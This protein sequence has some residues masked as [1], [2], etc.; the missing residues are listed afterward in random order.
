MISK[1]T[2]KY[3]KI[4]STVAL[5]VIV[6]MAVPLV[7]R[8]VDG[9]KDTAS[10][11][12]IENNVAVNGLYLSGSDR[13]AVQDAI[14]PFNG[15]IINTFEGINGVTYIVVFGDERSFDRMV[16][17]REELGK[18]KYISADLITYGSVQ[19]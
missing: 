1:L 10:D 19:N 2:T 6:A 4:I 11:L 9:N 16:E 5:I 17:I 13:Q 14:K 12:V 8:V 7:G 15:E 3:I 18:S